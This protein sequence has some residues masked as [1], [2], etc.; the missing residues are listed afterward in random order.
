MDAA[1]LRARRAARDRA[2]A[3]RRALIAGCLLVAIGAVAAVV[4]L[5]GRSPAGNSSS[6]RSA[7]GHDATTPAG[8]AGG[9]PTGRAGHGASGAVGPASAGA[10]ALG[11]AHGTGLKSPSAPE[12]A[13]ILMY[14]VINP[15]PPGAPFPGLYVPPGEFAE[16][17]QALAAAGFHAVTMDQLWANWKQGA[18]LPPGKPIVL[19]FD[20]GYQSQY[21][22]ALPV[23]RRL[24]WAGVEN[25]QL[26]G[27]PPSQGGLSQAQ[28][29]GLVAADW[30]LDTQG[31]SHADLITL[32]STELHYQV[33]VA[34]GEVQRL[35]HVAANWFCYP[36]GHYDAAVVEAVRAAGYRG[37]TTVVPGWAG[38]G[39][40]PYRLPRLRVL[41]GTGP[42][43]LLSEIAA[44]RDNS[45]PP[46]SYG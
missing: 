23:L 34:R 27:L 15:P 13:P 43:E 2:R 16:Q 5:A 21:T 44:I 14:H 41:G 1:R 46:P 28:V 10:P 31:F 9:A 36:S 35:Y 30:E 11:A 42:Q 25:L 17:M 8:H 39:G 37:S 32:D 6:A 22:N 20:N 19:T 26:T 45:Q 12:S 18:P 3:R 4:A 29:R 40:D 33:A 38:P 24:G 7:A